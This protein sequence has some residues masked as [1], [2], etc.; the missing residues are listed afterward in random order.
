MC[1]RLRSRVLSI[2]HVFIFFLYYSNFLGLL[3]LERKDSRFPILTEFLKVKVFYQLSVKTT[4]GQLITV[5]GLENKSNTE[6]I[7]PDDSYR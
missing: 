6:M 2:S 5:A 3:R 1:L 7:S 4:P